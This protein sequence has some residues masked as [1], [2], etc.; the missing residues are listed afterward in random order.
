MP[1]RFACVSAEGSLQWRLR[2]NCSVT[3]AQLMSLY[4][5]LALVSL[6]IA[7]FFWW[8][9]AVLVLPFTALELLALGAA[10]WVYARHA[11]DGEVIELHPQGLRVQQEEAGQ[12]VSEWFDPARVRVGMPNTADD[13][14]EI[15]SGSRLIKVGRYLRPEVRHHL[16][17]EIRQALMACNLGNP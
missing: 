15:R 7:A 3:P 11:T 6:T 2:R 14:I 10:F 12:V 16:G 8:H 17:Q 5:M 9:G 13:L 4:A 1:W